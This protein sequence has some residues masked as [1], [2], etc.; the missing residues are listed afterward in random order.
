[1]RCILVA[2]LLLMA[3]WLDAGLSP[4]EVDHFE[5][6]RKRA[7]KGEAEGQA[8]L[9]FCYYIGQGVRQDYEKAFHWL[10]RAAVTDSNAQTIIAFAYY[11]G[12]GVPQ[13]YAEAV[14]WYR[15]AVDLGN[16][17]AMV[18]LGSCY[19]RGEGVRADSVA[20]VGLW[21]RAAEMGEARA[22]ISRGGLCPGSRAGWR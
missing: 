12:E 7:E 9:G 2:P 8:M 19:Q 5:A 11:N 3:A 16:P 18:N 17:R 13:D 15:K 1:M 22:I 21:R 4:A 20:A 10:R 14:S 6:S